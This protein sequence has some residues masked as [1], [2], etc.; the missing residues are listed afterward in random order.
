MSNDIYL[1]KARESLDSAESELANRRYN[2]SA[3]R[4]YYA[5]FQAAVSAL[6]SI[7]VRRSRSG[8]WRHEYVKGQCTTELIH[9]HKRYPAEL[10]VIFERCYKL[11][12]EA[13]YEDYS[14]SKPQADRQFRAAR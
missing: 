6:L 2:C 1:E 9:R 14:V 7:A 4:A 8:K 5:C 3:N 13:D 11:R 12:E 10:S